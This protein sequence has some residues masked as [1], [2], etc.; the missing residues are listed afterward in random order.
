MKLNKVRMRLLVR[1]GAMGFAL[2]AANCDDTAA[3]IVVESKEAATQVA[4]AVE[5]AEAQA[6]RD[7]QEAKA[8]IVK[9]ADQAQATTENAV[10]GLGEKVD[11]VD[12]AIAERIREE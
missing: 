6:K 8:D 4:Q 2:G 7:T 11:E 5:S 1:A 9:A 3:A 12:K 10:E